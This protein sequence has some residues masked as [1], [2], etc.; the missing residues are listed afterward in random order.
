LCA[1]TG[2]LLACAPSTTADESTATF[3]GSGGATTTGA[4]GASFGGAGGAGGDDPLWSCTDAADADGDFV[5]DSL[6]LGPT[7]DTDDDGTPDYL[8]TDSDG[9]GW[10]DALEASNPLLPAG[11]PGSARSHVCDDLADTDGDG[12][13]DLRDLDSDNDGLTDAQEREIDP[14]GS[15]SCRVLVDCDGD[16]ILDIIEVAAGSDPT[17]AASQPEDPGLYFVLPYKAPVLTR[18]FEFSTGVAKADI[19][20]LIDTTKSMQPAIDDLKS[21][22]D[23]KVIP[24]ILNGDLSATPPIPAIDDAW[25][26]VGELRD[27]PWAP[28]G[29]PGDDVYRNQFASGLRGNVAPAVLSQGKYVAP[30]GVRSILTSLKADGGG[31]GPEATTQALWLATTSEP[32]AAT[33]GG[34]W[35]PAKPYPAPCS[36][37]GMFGVPCFRPQSLPIFVII[38]DAAFHNG[39]V[40]SNDYDPTKAGGTRSYQQTVDALNAAHANIVGVPVNTGG[41]G[42]AR[43]DLSDLAKKTGSLYFKA[44][45]GGSGTDQ[46]LVPT[47]DLDPQKGEV[48]DEVV[49]LLGLLAGAGLHDVTTKRMN[50]DCAGGLDCTG[51]GKPDIEYHNPPVLPD[52]EPYDASKLIVKIETVAS[53]ASPLPYASLTDT[54]FK[55]VRG[56][57]PVTF[58]VHAQNTTIRPPGLLVLRALV[59]VETPSGQLLGGKQ[60]IRLVYFVIPEYAAITK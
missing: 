26:G 48:S 51:D 23:T 25:I 10:P 11:T 50:Y 40:T 58:R 5:A 60:G 47:Q 3:T 24:K 2:A 53:Q 33:I 1:L 44:G 38:T 28:Y 13:P 35:S 12:I 45:F 17:D 29:Q 56:A 14:D 9:D 49:R 22:L 32:Y 8:D 6:E 37:A 21:S 43:S 34:L 18:D 41:A 46:P 52:T 20:F 55:S 4:G 31:D 7:N 16:G 27:V 54:T 42:L 39:P 57:A 59:R 15:K 19:Y 30:D 36:E